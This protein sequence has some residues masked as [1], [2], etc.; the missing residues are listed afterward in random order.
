MMM[1][2]STPEVPQPLILVR[3]APG[4]AAAPS[5]HQGHLFAT[6]C[7]AGKGYT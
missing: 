1:C 2:L 7:H 4:D 3:V 6:S 5:H